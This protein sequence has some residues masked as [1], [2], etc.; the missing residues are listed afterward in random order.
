MPTGLATLGGHALDS[1]HVR[2]PSHA[3]L[4]AILENFPGR[5]AS[6]GLRIVFLKEDSF[7]FLRKVRSG[8]RCGPGLER[9]GRGHRGNGA[10]APG[11]ASRGGV[12]VS[13]DPSMNPSS[14]TPPR[15]A[16]APA[17]MVVL[18]S[19]LFCG[20]GVFGKMILLSGATPA[21]LMGMRAIWASPIYLAILGSVAWIRRPDARDF[22][23]M[24]LWGI[25]G[26]WLGPRLT[27]EGLGRTTAGLERILIQT[28]PAWIVLLVW[29]LH[30]RR[31][32]GRVGLSLVLCY[33]GLLMACLGRDGER[34]VAD[35][36][37][38]AEILAGCLVW[39]LFVVR[40]GALHT[41]Y[42]V[43]LP[44]SVGMVVAAAAS[45]VESGVSGHLGSL[46][47][48]GASIRG[49]LALLVVFSTVAPSFLMQKGLQRLGPVRT[50]LLSL[51]GPSLVPL[52]T[53]TLLGETMSAPQ[54]IGLAVVVASSL[55]LNLRKE[56][57]A[58]ADRPA[59]SPP[60]APRS[61]A[62]SAPG[63]TPA[64]IRR[65]GLDRPLPGARRGARG[66]VS[67]RG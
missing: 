34:A 47:Q 54:A 28:S 32:T 9:E 36:L 42:G 63:A 40:V 46:L 65:T 15:A 45:A 7:A 11:E 48:P 59:G 53:S 57:S 66:G 58:S 29:F 31:P 39:S 35:M 51:A 61:L 16:W 3:V 62:G 19:I 12:S 6:W 44:T 26:F 52:A 20:K 64:K 5:R 4:F 24:S 27:F 21:D 22:L 13:S 60:R 33:G 41:R 2:S 30:K 50:G 67:P 38:V 17:V 1:R 10:V 25:V 56:V 18:A 23:R 55:P 37:G 49:S 8:I 43:V 14:S